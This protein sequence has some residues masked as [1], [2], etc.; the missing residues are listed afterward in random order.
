MQ[1]RL[2]KQLSQNGYGSRKDVKRII[3]SGLVLLNGKKVLD[4]NLKI[5]LDV[6]TLTVENKVISKKKNIYIM[7]NKPS[8][9]VTAAKDDKFSTVFDVLPEEFR[10]LTP[11]GRLDKDTEG[12]LLFTDNGLLVHRLTSPKRGVNKVYEVV[13]D[14]PWEDWYDEKLSEGLSLKDGYKCLPAFARPVP[15]ERPVPQARSVPQS[16]SNRVLLTISE[17]KYHQ[18]KRMF[19]ALGNHVAYLKRISVDNV[20]LDDSL[21]IGEWRFLTEEEISGLLKAVDL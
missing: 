14:S 15:Q 20:S 7:L 3:R 8:G 21:A 9:V 1:E 17:G 12:L 19:A 16:L 5:D 6:D 2:D 11:V 18:V 4:P 10:T 13:L